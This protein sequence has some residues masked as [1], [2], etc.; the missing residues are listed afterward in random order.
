MG[1]SQPSNS[2][3]RDCDEIYGTF[4]T[5]SQEKDDFAQQ[6]GVGALLHQPAQGHQV[7]CLPGAVR[8]RL[9]HNPTLPKSADDHPPPCTRP[10]APLARYGA[11]GRRASRAAPTAQQLH[12]GLGHALCFIAARGINGLSNGRTSPDIPSL[13]PRI[14]PDAGGR[15]PRF[16]RLD[17]SRDRL[18]PARCARGRP[19]QQPR[20]APL[21]LWRCRSS[22]R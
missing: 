12:H 16:W 11:M 18:G 20:R 2:P 10:V 19:A 9:V 1:A 15:R 3:N 22:A 14:G 5:Q 4:G 6:I 13:A 21:S 17:H 8:S 7:V